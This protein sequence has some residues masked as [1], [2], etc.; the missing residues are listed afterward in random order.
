MARRRSDSRPLLDAAGKP[1]VGY[2][3]Q[4]TRVAD[5]WVGRKV[6]FYCPVKYRYDLRED[7]NV[8][9]KRAQVQF[10]DSNRWHLARDVFVVPKEG[11]PDVPLL[12]ALRAFSHDFW[13]LSARG[14]LER[15]ATIY[16]ERM[17]LLT[18]PP[19][20]GWRLVAT[21]QVAALIGR[22]K[23]IE[24]PSLVPHVSETIEDERAHARLRMRQRSLKIA[25]L[26]LARHERSLE[27]VQKLVE[28]WNKRVATLRDLTLEISVET[29]KHLIAQP[30]DKT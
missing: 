24:G 13:W 6:R 15:R 1:V 18:A 11:S 14:S 27:R 16:E 8:L 30:K 5:P 28:R 25:E 17:P 26:T 3:C 21:S 9:V 29:K 2:V 20:E 19:R 12:K 22:A 7:R 10:Y 23:D 4:R